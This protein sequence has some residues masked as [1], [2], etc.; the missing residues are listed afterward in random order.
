M[1]IFE[2]DSNF[3][4]LPNGVSW[5]TST[6]VLAVHNSYRIYFRTISPQRAFSNISDLK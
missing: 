6:S 1:K 5:L 2:N 3:W 4:V